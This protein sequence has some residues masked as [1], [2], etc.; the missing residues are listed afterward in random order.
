MHLLLPVWL[1]PKPGRPVHFRW[2]NISTILTCPAGLHNGS[3]WYSSREV[4]KM[5]VGCQNEE[6]PELHLPWFP[7]VQNITALFLSHITNMETRCVFSSKEGVLKGELLPETPIM[8]P[9]NE[10]HATIYIQPDRKIQHEFFIC[11]Q[12]IVRNGT[13]RTQYAN[14]TYGGGKQSIQ[15][16]GNQHKIS[17]ELRP[18][19]LDKH[20]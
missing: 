7:D 15:T 3:I 13:C 1:R 16:N 20:Q 5:T 4:Y 9:L 11:K 8:G 18:S 6:E 12:G 2:V 19:N 17:D 14:G 10:I